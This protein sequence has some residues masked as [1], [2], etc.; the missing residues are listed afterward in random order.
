[1]QHLQQPVPL[2]PTSSTNPVVMRAV[3][4]GVS[5]MSPGGAAPLQLGGRNGNN[6]EGIVVDLHCLLPPLSV[7]HLR[8]CPLR[9]MVDTGGADVSEASN[10]PELRP[11]QLVEVNGLASESGKLLNGQRGLLCEFIEASSGMDLFWGYPPPRILTNIPLNLM[12]TSRWQ[13]RIGEKLVSLKPANLKKAEL[14]SSM[15][16]PPEQTAVSTEPTVQPS[17]RSR[18]RS[19]SSSSSSSSSCSKEREE[20]EEAPLKTGEEVE[21]FGLNSDAGK[22]FNGQK[23][24]LTEY[25]SDKD[26]WE[27]MISL[28]KVVSLRPRNL[29]R[30][31]PLPGA[32]LPGR[33]L[34]GPKT[35]G[36]LASLLGMGKAKEAENNHA[37]AKPATWQSVWARTSAEVRETVRSPPASAMSDEQLSYLQC[38]QSE[39]EK[40]ELKRRR[41]ESKIRRELDMV[42]EV[43]R[44]REEE[45]SQKIL[46]RGEAAL[47]D[48]DSSRSGEGPQAI[49]TAEAKRPNGK[50]SA[51]SS[52]SSSSSKR[53]KVSA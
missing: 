16:A 6:L 50:R 39:N 10:A 37:E 18:S 27:V 35:E 40:T 48:S 12:A 2:R 36:S 7:A 32:V 34:N 14:F 44:Q 31:K 33:P 15:P 21:I 5:N 45:R 11:G 13:V 51:S 49:P 25:C 38:F 1:M 47:S 20:K 8:F 52:S 43:I 42:L 41:R 22:A 24:V 3:Y 19:S 53:Q 30:A 9:A 28:E 26:R 29:R 46:F 23:G 17:R 4:P